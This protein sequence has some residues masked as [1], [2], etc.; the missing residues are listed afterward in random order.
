MA[1]WRCKLIKIAMEE[2][3]GNV[4][5]AAEA[6]DTYLFVARQVSKIKS[7]IDDEM[8]RHEK[9]IK[10]LK[11]ELAEA[12]KSCPCPSSALVHH[13]D[14]SEDNGSYHTC[15]ICGK[16]LSRRAAW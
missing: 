5:A 6:I 14:E 9:A 3:A 15:C 11:S 12:R 8:K 1:E 13:G 10:L 2:H 4:D 16:T 7:D